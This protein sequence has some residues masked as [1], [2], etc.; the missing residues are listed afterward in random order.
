MAIQIQWYEPGILLYTLQFP[1][2]WSELHVSIDQA[3]ALALAQPEREVGTI[4]D[5][6]G[7][8][9]VPSG[10]LS[11]GLKIIGKKPANAN[12][13][14]IVGASSAI[15][16]FHS[17]VRTLY[18]R[19]THYVFFADDV[20]SAAARLRS[21]L[22]VSP[23][24]EPPTTPVPTSPRPYPTPV[25]KHPVTTH[26]F[27]TLTADRDHFLRWLHETDSVYEDEAVLYISE[28]YVQALPGVAADWKQ[29]EWTALITE[30]R[31][32]GL[33][34]TRLPLSSNP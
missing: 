30:L 34:L 16:A 6:Q 13:V 3:V 5:L 29:I 32:Y 2:S 15:R 12:R 24:P 10:A 1:F 14:A 28:Q 4:L 18:P 9:H 23:D 26:I 33:H 31:M 19:I 11:E 21:E 7:L 27:E 25:F 8:P 22:R 20:A 17:V